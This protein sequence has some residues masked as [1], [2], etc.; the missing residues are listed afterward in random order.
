MVSKEVHELDKHA[1]AGGRA[2]AAVRDRCRTS[3]D[4]QGKARAARKRLSIGQRRV[5]ARNRSTPIERDIDFGPL[6]DFVGFGL[7]LAQDAA[8]RAFARRVGDTHLKPGRFAAMLIVDCNPGLTQKDLGRAVARDKSSV[9]QLI[10]ELQ[11]EGLLDRRA[12]E[13]DRRSR[14]LTLT[15]K[16]RAAV[17]I[18]LR[19][20]SEHE[21][22]L[23]VI[24]GDRRSELMSSLR[25]IADNII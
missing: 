9:T 6:A 1:G 2:G 4:K 24:V 23:N 15:P 21:R 22:Q 12:S 7:R 3:D 20:A 13:T 16:G 18:M 5:V 19:R 11:R 25:R 10:Q 17:K 8:F 14:M